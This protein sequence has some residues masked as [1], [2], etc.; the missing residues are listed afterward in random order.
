[1]GHINRG[2]AHLILHITDGAAHLNTQFGIQ[3]GQRLIHK[4]HL[5]MDD[6]GPCQGHS[7]LLAAG[8]TLRQTVL[9]FVNF[10]H[11]QDLIH[12]LLHLVLWHLADFQAIFHILTDRQVGEYSIALEHHADV[13]FLGRYII[14]DLVVK[15]DGSSLYAVK[16]GNH[17]QQGGLAAS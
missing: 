6:N 8:Q 14:D 16:P 3:I 5:G 4:K 12:P 13:S 11:P 2:N 17:A 7:L 9:V 10:Y 1:M 15:L